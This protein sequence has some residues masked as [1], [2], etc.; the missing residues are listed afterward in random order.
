MKKFYFQQKS[1]SPVNRIGS[2]RTTTYWTDECK[3]KKEV[4]ERYSTKVSSGSHVIAV[5]TEEQYIEKYGAER[6][7]EIKRYWNLSIGR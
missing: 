7:A 3:T 6:A 2:Y 4:R 1:N 5:F